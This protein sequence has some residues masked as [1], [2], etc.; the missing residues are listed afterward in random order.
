MRLFFHLWGEMSILILILILF[1][2]LRLYLEYFYS[3]YFVHVELSCQVVLKSMN[4]S[5]VQ[6]SHSAN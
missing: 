3:F 6:V 1:E 4:Y 5:V 2:W